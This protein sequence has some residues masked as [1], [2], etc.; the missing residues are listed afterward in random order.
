MTDKRPCTR[1]GELLPEEA[2]PFHKQRP[3]LRLKECS[4]CYEMR[5]MHPSARPPKPYP[6][7]PGTRGIPCGK[8]IR[9]RERTMCAQCHR[10][11]NR[12]ERPSMSRK[13]SRKNPFKPAPR[14]SYEPEE[15]MH[16]PELASLR[17]RT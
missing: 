15:Y 5:K 10:K 9:N 14:F 1:C 17:L 11:E 12:P 2:F 4:Q 7:C 16:K 13:A 8:N 3:T 6:K